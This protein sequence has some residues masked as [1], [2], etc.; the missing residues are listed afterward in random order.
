MVLTRSQ[1][2]ALELLAN[3]G[4]GSTVPALVRCGCTANDLHRL[5]RDGLVRAQ[6]IRAR[7]RR[8]SPKDFH[9]HISDVGRQALARRDDF[10]GRG[11]I[12]IKLV[13]ILLFV[14]G[15]LAGVVVGAF[16]ITRA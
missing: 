14:L 15:V 3:A 8:P 9:L 10:A 1:R 2:K 12:S 13:L 6:R 16:M 4:E 11:M 7:D 5:V